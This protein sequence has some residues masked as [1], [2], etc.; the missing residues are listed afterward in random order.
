MLTGDGPVNRTTGVTG[1]ESVGVAGG[2]NVG[3]GEGVSVA[4]AG[5]TT[6]GWSVCLP[7]HPTTRV[8]IP[9]IDNIMII[10]S[11]DFLEFI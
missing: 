6:T 10:D 4:V 9:A 8:I 3:L 2:V 11:I 1:A 7:A 5:D